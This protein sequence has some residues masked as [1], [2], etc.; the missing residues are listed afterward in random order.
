M[1]GITLADSGIGF[2]VKQGLPPSAQGGYGLFSV[3]ER[4]V[5]LSGDVQIDSRAGD[6]T[7]VAVTL[8][9]EAIKGQA[10]D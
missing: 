4:L 10:S 2:D 9:L 7:L 5:Y 6:G 3:R 1:T 8:P